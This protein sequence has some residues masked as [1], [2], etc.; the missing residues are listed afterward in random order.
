MQNHTHMAIFAE[1]QADWQGQYTQLPKGK[2]PSRDTSGRC[3]RW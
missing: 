3:F 1:T 2:T